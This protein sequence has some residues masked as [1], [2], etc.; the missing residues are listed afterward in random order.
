MR[1]ALPALLTVAL[2]VGACT[3]GTPLEPA[4]T[5]EAPATTTTAG[6]ETPTTEGSDTTTTSAPSET[7][8]TEAAG[9]GFP[10]TI[11][12][13]NGDVTIEARPERIVSLSPTSTEILF[14]LGAGDQVVAADSFSDFPADAP[15]DPDLV[16]LS[17]NVEAIV[18]EHDP[19]LVVMTF[20]PG[21]VVASFEALGVPVV[22]HL[23]PVTLDD[24]YTQYEQL[25]AATANAA[26]AAAAV[27]R[28]QADLDTVVAEVGDAAAG[29]TYYHELDPTFFSATSTTFIGQVYGLFGMENIADPADA[30]GAAFG[31]PQLS[32]EFILDADPDLVFLADTKCCDQTAGTVAERPGWSD[33]SAVPDGVVELDDDVASRWGPRIV[34]FAQVIAEA[35]L[36]LEPAA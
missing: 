28:I 15:T 23:A 2:M 13:G 31:F 14:D 11:A 3:A 5:T 1:R 34:D 35:V 32:A 4:P 33:L 24:T 22:V 7:T 26:T 21:E 18:E 6:G 16:A 19:D 9:G 20:D 17:P 30:D 12:A 8:T 36:A 27:A 10:V 29:L 25:G